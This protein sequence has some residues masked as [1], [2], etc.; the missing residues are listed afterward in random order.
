MT[1]ITP[2]ATDG[3]APD[4]KGCGLRCGY[5]LQRIVGL[6]RTPGLIFSKSR[7]ILSITGITIRETS[8][9]G[10]GARFEIMVPKGAWR[11][12]A[13]HEIPLK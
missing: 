1:L 3:F 11:D 9:P 8:E 2:D 6:G 13:E 5:I 12:L 4:S 7:N 10:K